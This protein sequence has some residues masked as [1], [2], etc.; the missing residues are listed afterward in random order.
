[1]DCIHIG[2]VNNMPDLALQDTEEQ[3]LELL[4]AASGN[5]GV[6]VQFFALPGIPRSARWQQYLDNAYFD[7]SDLQNVRLDAAIVTGTEP[8]Q[9]DLRREPYW[10]AM[11]DVLDWAEENTASTVLS[12]LAAH[13][14][15]LYSDGIGRH[16]LGHKRFGVFDF[17]IL[18][19]HPLTGRGASLLQFPHSRWNDLPAEALRAG[20]YQIL[21]ESPAHGVDLFV[22]QKR[23][24]L[25]VHFQG[26][27]EYGRL[28]LFKEYRRDVRRFLKRERDDYPGL[29]CGYFDAAAVEL[30][31][32][33]RAQA[34]DQPSE[35]L[36]ANFP[37]TPIAGPL[38]HT[39]RTS[40]ACLY[41]RW[42]QYVISKKTST[43]TFAAA[44]GMAVGPK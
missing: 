6:H 9:C 17:R 23:K 15:V 28:T 29:P 35:E 36:L 19:D 2:L 38:Q 8:H 4:D 39:W 26:H 34:L 43:L 20:G 16:H 13:A 25:F 3:F 27:P 18:H 33:F 44:S 24:S 7:L 5:I 40:A 32:D 42:L 10:G 21:S 1:V 14:G 11:A 37:E 22:K 12:C 30:L 41:R 31:N